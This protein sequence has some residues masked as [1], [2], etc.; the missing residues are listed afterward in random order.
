LEIKE[1]LV[2]DSGRFWNIPECDISQSIDIRGH[3]LRI[4]NNGGEAFHDML[5][6][7]T[8]AK[9]Y[10]FLE[11]YIFRHD[12]V[13]R[14]FK[15]LLIK[16][17]REGVAVYV[18]F[19]GIGNLFVPHDFWRK[20][21]R[22]GAQVFEYGSIR[23]FLD[24]FDSKKW[25]RDHRKMLIIDDKV[26]FIGGINIGREYEKRWRD[27]HLKIEG[28]TVQNIKKIFIDFWNDHKK[29][30]IEIS[31]EWVDDENIKI[32]HNNASANQF[33]IRK[34]YLDL[35]NGAASNLYLTSSYFVPDEGTMAAL[36]NASNRGV[37]VEIILPE[38]SDVW[39]AQF[40]TF[41]LIERLLRFGVKI[42]LYR[43]TMI[44]SKMATA[45]HARS[46]IG[47]ANLDNRS[48]RRN[49]EIIAEIKDSKFAFEIERMFECDKRNCHSL[50][51]SQWIHR[52]KSRI[53]WENFFG[54]FRNYL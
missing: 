31:G 41:S 32:Y 49:Y 33:P 52:P 8:A 3:H 6:E 30:K 38:R 47:S 34:A 27:T 45:D 37:N 4:F 43:K 18:V 46:I 16:K 54:L 21:T 5:R 17:A 24:Y 15:K 35:I 53:F 28:S 40:A 20:L 50:N 10:I 12:R 14:V 9:R 26:A 23:S 22:A 51:L 13:G 7:I 48:L 44:H 25:I 36:I 2:K 42:H 39:I 11:S 1:I 19:D 29:K